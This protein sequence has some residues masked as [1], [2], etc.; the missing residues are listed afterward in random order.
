MSRVSAVRALVLGA[1]VL[2]PVVS[3]KLSTEPLADQTLCTHTSPENGGCARL[4]GVVLDSTGHPIEFTQLTLRVDSSRAN[5][6]AYGASVVVT[7]TDGQF[8]LELR[9]FNPITPVP[10]PDTITTRVIFGVPDPSSLSRIIIDSTTALLHI[11]PPGSP[12]VVDTITVR[13]TAR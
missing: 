2:G 6:Q 1:L 7:T 11:Q 12:A 5:P 13:S 8:G 9:R 4:L 10:S 3:C